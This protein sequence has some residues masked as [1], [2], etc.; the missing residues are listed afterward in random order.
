M[1]S[2]SLNTYPPLRIANSQLRSLNLAAR[3]TR[4]TVVC[5]SS[6]S[7]GTTTH[8][9]ATS[10]SCRVQYDPMLEEY[11]SELG[12]KTLPGRNLD[13]AAHCN[14]TQCV[15]SYSIQTLKRQ[16]K[17]SRKFLNASA[18]RVS[19]ANQ[20]MQSLP[21]LLSRQTPPQDISKGSS[22]AFV[23]IPFRDDHDAQ[24]ST[25]MG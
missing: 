21:K 15:I 12:A 13:N 18:P 1:N 25:F 10:C 4:K 24:F 14:P 6:T 11:P 16:V 3:L 19:C 23:C 17:H 2:I 5:T 20:S 9:G 7:V 22:C 8:F